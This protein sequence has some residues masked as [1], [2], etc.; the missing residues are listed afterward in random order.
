M[1]RID[2]FPT[3]TRLGLV[4]AL[5]LVLM[6]GCDDGVSDPDPNASVSNEARA[7]A[8]ERTSEVLQAG[9]ALHTTKLVDDLTGGFA[10]GLADEAVGLDMELGRDFTLPAP[11]AAPMSA[12]AALVRARGTQQ[13]AAREL[14]AHEDALGRGVMRAPG[15]L[16]FTF[17]EHNLDGSVSVIRVFEGDT[18]RLVRIERST[19]WPQGNLLLQA[20][21]DEI[22]VDLGTDRES[23]ADDT[24]LYLNSELK[25][26][27]GASLAR[28]IDLREQGGLRDDVRVSI[29]STYRPRPQHPRLVDVVSTLEVDL[30]TLAIESDDRFVSVDRNTRFVGTAADGGSPRVEESLVLEQPVAEGEEPCGGTLERDIH[31]ARDRALLR[32][33]DTASWS[34]DGGGSLSRTL[35]YDD[36]SQDS[37]TLTEDSNGVVHLS[38]A[39]R[40]GTTTTGSFDEAQ[41]SFEFTSVYPQGSDPVRRAVQGSTNADETAW[42]LEEQVT[43]LD[44]F[45]ERNVLAANENAE[46]RTL[47]G[48]HAG[49]DEVVEFELQTNL[50]ETRLEGFVQNDREQRIEFEL[51]Q[52]ADGGSLVDFVAT[53]PGVRVEG[54][55]EIGA[56]GCGQ[57]TLT[58]TES[59]STVTIDVSFCDA[60]LDQAAAIVAGQL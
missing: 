43:Y 44:A 5:G 16:L 38:A 9:S 20:I 10:V 32:W 26:V 41:H 3:R 11:S 52:F 7:A 46:G 19:T 12:G 29:V 18:D 60:E 33:T 40:N 17:T 58:V 55:L 36:N 15:D 57:G 1:I 14:V 45:V 25:F 53:E 30:H 2:R 24:W 42:Q 35:A 28:A 31:F 54:H 34:C 50:D 51:E 49:R 48:S 56:D 4:T 27:G 37:L 8:V 39:E 22:L 21:E 23:E 47:I 59:G 6:A 13:K